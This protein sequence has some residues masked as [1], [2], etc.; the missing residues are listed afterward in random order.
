MDSIE[1]S[2]AI[3][4]RANIDVNGYRSPF[5]KRRVQARMLSTHCTSFEQYLNL[6]H[7]DVDER[8]LFEQSFSIPLSSF[9]RDPW[10]FANIEHHV[11]PEIVRQ[12]QT[13]GQRTVRIWSA[14]CAAGQ[15]AY[16]ISMQLLKMSHFKEAGFRVFILATDID[17]RAL[18]RAKEGLFNPDEVKNLRFGDIQTFFTREGAM[19]RVSQQLREM[20]CFAKHDLVREGNPGPPEALFNTYDL[21]LCRNVMIYYEPPMQK[22]IV[23]RLNSALQHGGYLALGEYEN[24]PDTAEGQYQHFAH[25]LPLYKKK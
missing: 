7:D 14:G 15:E 11:L 4:H 22:T 17:T 12:K 9:N 6:L 13:L 5:V 23:Q 2:H 18:Q 25:G 20:I 10:L 21:I 19:F 24:L 8:E 3:V 1:Y 16:S